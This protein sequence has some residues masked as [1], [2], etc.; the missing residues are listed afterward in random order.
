METLIDTPTLV[1]PSQH[2]RGGQFWSERFWEVVSEHGDRVRQAFAHFDDHQSPMTALGVAMQR[3]AKSTTLL[4]RGQWGMLGL[5]H[6][7][8]SLCMPSAVRRQVVQIHDYYRMILHPD[9]L[10]QGNTAML[11]IHV[12]PGVRSDGR[13]AVWAEVK[14]ALNAYL[15][16]YPV[17]RNDRLPMV[18]SLMKFMLA[19][20]DILYRGNSI[21]DDRFQLLLTEEL[22]EQDTPAYLDY[23]IEFDFLPFLLN[24]AAYRRWE[25][26]NEYFGSAS[27]YTA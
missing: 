22:C 11:T 2:V 19:D 26:K 9:L 6:L 16:N 23:R 4:Q 25:Q 24:N 5:T 21:T 13:V 7:S 17:Q 14:K 12:T 15:D 27:L 18:S 8:D 3:M 1:L 10:T 20:S